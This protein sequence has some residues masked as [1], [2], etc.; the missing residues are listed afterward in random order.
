MN[1][2]PKKLM[3]TTVEIHLLKEGE[4]F[5]A[6]CAETTL[7]SVQHAMF[8]AGIAENRWDRF[9]HVKKDISLIQLCMSGPDLDTG[10]IDGGRC[11]YALSNFFL[12]GIED[13]KLF[14]SDIKET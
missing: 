3:L 4:D 11:Y 5:F 8:L 13:K 6:S 12:Q 9:S 1:D 14:M 2:K 10:I 7:H